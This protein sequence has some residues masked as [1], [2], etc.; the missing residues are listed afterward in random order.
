MWSKQIISRWAQLGYWRFVVA[1]C[2]SLLLHFF[3]LEKFYLYLPAPKTERQVIEAQLVMPKKQVAIEPTIVPPKSDAQ[4]ESLPSVIKPRKIKLK[5]TP[6]PLTHIAENSATETQYTSVQTAD[7]QPQQASKLDETKQ[8]ELPVES[9]VN[10]DELVLPVT[11]TQQSEF[12]DEAEQA[13]NVEK[14]DI[15]PNVYQYVS[16]SFDVFTDKEPSL[17][18]SPVGAANIVYAQLPGSSQYHIKSLIQPKG[19]ASLLVPDLLQ[20]SEGEIGDVGLQPKQYLYQFGDKKNKTYRAEFDWQS[21]QL[22]LHNAKGSQTLALTEGTQDL[23]SFMYQFMFLQPLQKTQ[24]TITNGKKVGEYSYSFEGEEVI[25][26]KIGTLNTVHLLRASGESDKK[27]E[28][29]L[30]LDYQYVP[31]K[32]RETEKDGKVYELVVSSLKTTP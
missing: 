25:E 1:L 16:T 6:S 4:P 15:N 10:P 32:I 14:V 21:K 9:A 5:K 17:G 3:V 19:L 13:M 24:M 27:T 29:W 2:L 20:T 12:A 31:V 18:S 26:T 30:A 22:S 28:L 7:L 11:E 8:A 23:L